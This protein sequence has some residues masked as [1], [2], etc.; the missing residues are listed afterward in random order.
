MR[1]RNEQTREALAAEYALGPLQG[2]ARR[3]FERSLKDDPGLRGLV[4]Q[5]QARLAPLDTLIEPVQP[6]ARV[7]HAIQSRLRPTL[8]RG[9]GTRG[10]GI[11]S[12]WSSLGFWR[13]A[14]AASS[15]LALVLAL[16][17]AVLT[18]SST[19]REL[20]V[21]VMSD[22]GGTPRMTISWPV[23][24]RREPKLRV[25]VISHEPMAPG[26]SWELWMLPGGEQKPVSLGLIST[27]PTQE[28]HIPKELARVIDSAWGLAMSVEPHGGSPTGLPTG[29]VLYKGPSTEL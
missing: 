2:R 3:R 5:W 20:M 14:T 7:W 23:Q 22:A 13:A 29:P 18:P 27:D 8:R 21:A 19:P 6:P 15:A 10:M 25:H 9:V 26:T 28:L 17:M 11:G 12:F 1:Y 24:P 16:G 4:A